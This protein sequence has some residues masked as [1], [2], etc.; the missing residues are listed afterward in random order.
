MM[1]DALVEVLMIR[2]K[3]TSTSDDASEKEAME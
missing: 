2:S 3:E 1:P